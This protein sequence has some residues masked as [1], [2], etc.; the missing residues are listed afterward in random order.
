MLV[1][2][3]NCNASY[4]VPVT[5]IGPHGREV[6]CAKC[7]DTFFVE[8]NQEAYNAALDLERLAGEI[9]TKKP[10][11]YS[12]QHFEDEYIVQI[13]TNNSFFASKLLSLV[14]LILLC[15]LSLVFFYNR[16]NTYPEIAKL[17]EKAGIH[18]TKNIILDKIVTQHIVDDENEN[19]QITGEIVNNNSFKVFLPSLRIS[20]HDYAGNELLGYTM[21]TKN[22]ILL[23]NEQYDFSNII[24]NISPYAATITVEIGNQIEFLLR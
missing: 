13:E 11:N 8:P 2:C 17:Y 12:H 15:G 16:L 22:E 1:V 19:L 23:P 4:A 14:L 18:S 10:K 5:K 7:S 6:R 20:V 21:E 24:T 3:K 9:Q